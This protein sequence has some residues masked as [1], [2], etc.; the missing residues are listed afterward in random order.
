[1]PLESALVDVH[2][3][4]SRL[5]DPQWVI[6]DGSFFLPSQGVN[7]EEA[8]ASSHIPGSRFFDIDRIA[9]HASP[10]PH[11]LPTAEDFSLAV[12][13]LGIGQHTG[14]VVYDRNVFMASARVWW[15]FRCFGHE[16]VRV[17]DG[18]LARWRRCGL[19]MASGAAQQP[20][21]PVGEAFSA[22]A[23]GSDLVWDLCSVRNWLLEGGQIVDARSP[24]RFKGSEAEPRQ[25][26]RSGGMP[27]SFNVHF[28]SLVSE[29]SHELL[30]PEAITEVFAKA[31][32]DLEKPL[33]ATC[34]TGVTAC[35]LALALYQCGK[36]RIPVY[37]GSW[38][39]WGGRADTPV[40]CT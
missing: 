21:A 37:D 9:D 2:W 22:L 11:M 26:V 29:D 16:N 19:P 24:S 1:M 15:M 38:T 35:I 5:N 34:G 14:V 3:L 7:P 23:Q 4:S 17:L 33:V 6:L 25:G 20:L 40:V 10:L 31:G 12:S 32:V 39:E 8:F 27:G 30:P 36:S 13:R 28:R 18:G